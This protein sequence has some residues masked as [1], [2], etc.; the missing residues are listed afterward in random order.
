MPNSATAKKRLRQSID[1]RARNR[2]VR[3]ALRTQIKKVR[4]A[5]AAGDVAAAE[6]E[7]RVAVK[8][9]DQTAAKNVLH[10]NT[11][12]RLKSRLSKAVK[13]L[14]TKASA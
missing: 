12:A 14:K 13:S 9:L 11:A 7:F 1:R 3:S 8:K 6:N 10:A 2:T 4:S 5:V